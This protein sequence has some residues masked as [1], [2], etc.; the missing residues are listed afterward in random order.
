MRTIITMRVSYA[1]GD[2]KADELLEALADLDDE[3]MFPTGA[4]I[5]TEFDYEWVEVTCVD[6]KVVHRHKL[7]ACNRNAPRTFSKLENI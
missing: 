6:C 4:D 7:L 3:G 5:K 2:P 1:D